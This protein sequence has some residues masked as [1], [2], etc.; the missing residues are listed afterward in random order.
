MADGGSECI[1]YISANKII[2]SE[3][4]EVN[5]MRCAYTEHCLVGKVSDETL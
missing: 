4:I 1:S 3:S 5:V 2:I